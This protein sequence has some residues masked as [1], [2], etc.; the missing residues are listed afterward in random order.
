MNPDIY[1]LYVH[2]PFCTSKCAYCGFYSEPVDL[3]DT[4]RLMQAILK[5]LSHADTRSVRTVYI[6]G[7]SPSCLPVSQLA[8]LVKAIIDQCSDITEFTVECNPGQV[9]PA[10]LERLQSLG[11][12]RLSIGAQSFDSQELQCLGRKHNAQIIKTAVHQAREAGFNNISLDLIFAVCGSTQATWQS[13]LDQAIALNPEH[14][15]VYALTLEQGTPL[16]EAVEQGRYSAIDESTDRAMYE[17]AIDT[18][19]RAGYEHYEISNF[20]KPG[21]E[22]KHNIG[23]WQ[24]RPYIGVGPSAAS[25]SSICRTRN[26][27]DIRTYEIA[28]ES[29]RSPVEETVSISP[30]ERICETA[31]LNLRTKNGI[32]VKRF[33]QVTGQDPLVLFAGPIRMHCEQGLLT[34]EKERI[35]LTARAL[36]IADYVLCDFAALDNIRGHSTF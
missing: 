11:V 6:G 29:G 2:I 33:K 1:G 5:E 27:S 12:N 22:C 9:I 15:S 18:L 30:M 26:F 3:H 21:C 35:F 17:Q 4:G 23:Y 34:I 13:G 10:M 25:S 31:V 19:I 14:L 32:D 28:M 8:G 36:P 24:N 16:A 20:A 7:G